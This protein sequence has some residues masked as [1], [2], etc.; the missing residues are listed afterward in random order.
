MIWMITSFV[1]GTGIGCLCARLFFPI[2]CTRVNI[3]EEVVKKEI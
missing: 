1:A 3:V 2:I